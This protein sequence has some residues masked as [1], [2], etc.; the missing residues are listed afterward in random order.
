MLLE[1]NRAPFFKPKAINT[2][3][4]Y[5]DARFESRLK[6]ISDVIEVLEK[7]KFTISDLLEVLDYVCKCFPK[8]FNIFNIYE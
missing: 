6:G 4:E 3:N 7:S 8:S 2:I 1:K 5:I